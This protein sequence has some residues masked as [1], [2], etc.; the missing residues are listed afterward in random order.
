M[1]TPLIA[2]PPALLILLVVIIA[3]LTDALDGARAAVVAEQE[4]HAA[5]RLANPPRKGVA[6]WPST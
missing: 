6:A 1:S 2:M 5:Y 3:D 4:S